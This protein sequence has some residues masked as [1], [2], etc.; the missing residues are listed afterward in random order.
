M[1]SQKNFKQAWENRKLVGG[2]LQAAHVRP[3]YHLYEDLFQEGLIM[4]ATMLDELSSE[5]SR[6]EIDKLSFRK[7]LW[8]TLN[9]LRREQRHCENDTSLDEAYDLGE[10]KN[11]ETLMILKQEAQNMTKVEQK[12]LFEHLLG[13]KTLKIIAVECDVPRRSLNR[14][15]RGLLDKLREKLKR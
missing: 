12:I 8:Q 5:K 2:A 10:E 4:Y 3:D 6:V 13:D 15:K 7:I 9:A 11:L 1:I 14:L